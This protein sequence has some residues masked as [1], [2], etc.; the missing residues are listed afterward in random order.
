MSIALPPGTSIADFEILDVLG[1]GGFSIVYRAHDHSRMQSVVAIKE[2]IPQGLAQRKGLDV[3]PV[4]ADA[5]DIFNSALQSFIQEGQ[6]LHNLKDDALLRV[7]RLVEANRTAYMVM[8]YCDGQTLAQALK[9]R[10]DPPSE[11]WLRALLDPMLGA[12]SKIHAAGRI[13]CDI[14][15]DNI[16]VLKTGKPVLLDLG[17]ARR[18]IGG[19]TKVLNLMVKEGYAPI[20][21]YAETDDNRQGPCTDIYALGAVMHF[22]LRGRPPDP[23]SV[24][25][26]NDR[27]Q[28]LTEALQ[29]SG[30][31]RSFLAAIDKA[32]CVK[33]KDRPQSVAE[34]QA[35]LRV[36][37]PAP[38]AKPRPAL[39]RI[40]LMAGAGLVALLVG[41]LLIRKAPEPRTT[42]V[43]PA[44]PATPLTATKTYEPL[45]LLDEI[46][47]ARN[48]DHAVNVRPNRLSVVTGKDELILRVKSSRPGYVYLFEVPTNRSD[49]FLVFPNKADERNQIS[50]GTDFVIPRADA[51]WG[52]TFFGPKGT[53]QFL[54]VVSDE[55][56]DLSHTGWQYRSPNGM[57]REF[58]NDTAKK[59]Y[60]DATG[61]LSMFLGTAL[62]A[63]GGAA[64]CSNLYGA[65]HFAVEEMDP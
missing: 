22:A 49:L 55:P 46:F 57:D 43:Q 34:F 3:V 27:Y 6:L 60:Q 53:N 14:A 25:V 18:V 45:K 9:A 19:R 11:S 63:Q 2:F 51:T 42:V 38:I 62:C 61:D 13:H 8:E 17:A 1:E 30:Y 37:D 48:K 7:H 56:R 65:A 12:V 59:A 10:S 47:E 29:S 31:S 39:N 36:P 32:L 54:L 52:L 35:L 23:A 16:L 21:Q 33:P 24:R 64:T 50:A 40:W 58:S 28:P 4:S 26:Q 15:P 41:A 20:E 44:P 5:E